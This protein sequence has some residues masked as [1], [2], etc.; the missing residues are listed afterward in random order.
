MKTKNYRFCPDSRTGPHLV[1]TPSVPADGKA[2]SF[3]LRKILSS[4]ICRSDHILPTFL[5]TRTQFHHSCLTHT[6]SCAVTLPSRYSP[7]P[8]GRGSILPFCIMCRENPKCTE[9][10][11]QI[12][13][14]PAP[15]EVPLAPNSSKDRSR[16]ATSASAM[17]PLQ[18]Q[19]SYQFT[20]RPRIQFSAFLQQHADTNTHT[21]TRV[22]TYTQTWMTKVLNS[23]PPE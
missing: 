1:E 7:L 14:V 4:P 23:G 17:I 10:W 9:L 6:S 8:G 3:R 5:W 11:P 22:C 21:N 18:A 12:P 13:Q 15:P 19:N 2:L 16:D 20:R